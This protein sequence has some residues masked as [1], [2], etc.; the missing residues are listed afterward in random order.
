MHER[1]RT[2]LIIIIFALSGLCGL[3]LS[4]YQYGRSTP[5]NEVRVI[6]TFHYPTTRLKQLVGDHRAGEKIFK[7]FCSTCHAIKPVVDIQAPR[8]GDKKIWHALHRLGIQ[9]LLSMT[10][11]GKGAMPARGG[12][13]E[14]SDQQLQETIQYMLD[15]SGSRL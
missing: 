14:C 6:Q 8:I 9:T 2:L 15:E 5:Q 10:I 13:F 1:N 3:G 7:E 4:Y 12:C 11:N